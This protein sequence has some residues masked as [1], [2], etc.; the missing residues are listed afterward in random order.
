M[1]A[2]TSQPTDERLRRSV[3]E[4]LWRFEPIRALGTDTLKVEV[5]DGIVRLDG[6]VS[7]EAHKLAASNLVRHVPGVKDVV[8]RLVSDEELEQQIAESLA[9]NRSTRQHR[10]VVN[11]VRGIAGLYG[12][13]PTED[14]AE[15]VRA[16]AAAV[17]GV[18][19]V[20]SRLRVVPLGAPVVLAWQCSVEGRPLAK[21]SDQL[22]PAGAGAADPVPGRSGP[23]PSAVA[24]AETTR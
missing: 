2:P 10:I 15:S 14:D 5:R 16:V 8:N 12:V 11:V 20:E 22:A 1:T 7:S 4:S 13:V 6:L 19:G 17:P 3:M 9:A 18:R 23:A 21:P 24:G